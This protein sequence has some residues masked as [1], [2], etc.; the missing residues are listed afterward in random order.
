[1]ELLLAD[2]P[3]KQHGLRRGV[4]N[5]LAAWEPDVKASSDEQ[6]DTKIFVGGSGDKEKDNV[7]NF[8]IW[9]TMAA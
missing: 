9:A 7:C 5:I 2:V 6:A 4:P 8:H 1:M 3:Q